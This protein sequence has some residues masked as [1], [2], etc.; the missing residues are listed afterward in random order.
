MAPDDP[1]DDPSRPDAAELAS[2][3]SDAA[4][5]GDG[6]S[7]SDDGGG[8][9]RRL[10]APGRPA[11]LA[12]GAGV[13]LALSLPPWGWWPLA[14]V[15]IALFDRSL[16]GASA[17][18]RFRRAWL[19]GAGL[20]IPSTLWMAAFTPPGY[21]FQVAG[22]S[23][24]L[25]VAVMA[26]P[27]TRWRWVALPGCWLL[28]EAVKG[29]WPFGGVP[30]SELAMGQVAGPLAPL[31]RVG[32]VLLIGA[33]TVAVGLALSALLDR[34]FNQAIGLFAAVAVVLAGSTLAPRGE[35]TGETI[36]VAYVQGG[37]EQGTVD[38]DTD[39]R[40]VF[41]AHLDASAAVPVGTDLTVWPENV[42]NV[43]GPITEAQEGE[44][45]ADLAR[46]KQTT[47]VVGVVE[48]AGPDHFR[49]SAIVFDANGE[50]I[51]RYE[52]VRRVPFGEFV[53]LRSFLEKVAGGAL[54]AKDAIIGTE[55]NTVDTPAARLGIVISWEVFFGDRGRDAVTGRGREADLLLNPTNGSSYKGTQVQTQQIS[56]SRL[57]ALESGRWMVQ[58]AP[59]GFSAFVSDT[60]TV[61]QRSR[62][63]EERVE[64]RE[65][66]LRSGQTLAAL[67]GAW[68]PVFLGIALIA[69]SRGLPRVLARRTPTPT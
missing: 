11:L 67:W 38:A 69:L 58:V 13:L 39:D 27:S 53:P 57:R 14:F 4:G 30:L 5:S 25:G 33:A 18:S 60:G 68:P 26:S 34:R 43:D 3:G 23:T 12:L 7:D 37:G 36:T 65:V 2:V 28:Y 1:S 56:S 52:K 61:H 55:S 49:N 21:V 17:W 35:A 20:L 66:P 9:R 45:L 46:E 24:F 32:G 50:I 59:T 47:L 16:A 54:P 29:R 44:E 42:V 63:S 62:V 41:L 15:G 22:F 31:A 10:R 64:T 8:G 6:G 51:A 40:E 19:T 48:G